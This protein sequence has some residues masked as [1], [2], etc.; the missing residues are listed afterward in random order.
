LPKLYGYYFS[1]LTYFGQQ[2]KVLDEIS[3]AYDCDCSRFIMNYN[4][5]IGSCS[6]FFSSMLKI[7]LI[8]LFYY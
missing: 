1:F 5:N 2:L 4:Q 8:K 6:R 3:L 7:E